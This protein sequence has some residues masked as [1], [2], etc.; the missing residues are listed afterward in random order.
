M[1]SGQESRKDYEYVRHGMVNIFM[2]NEPLKGNGMVE[3]T[4]YKTKKDWAKFVK[5]IADELYVNGK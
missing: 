1:K 5:R 3:V 4:R 2:A